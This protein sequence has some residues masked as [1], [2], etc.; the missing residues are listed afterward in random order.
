MAPAGRTGSCA[1]SARCARRTTCRRVRGR[2]TRRTMVDPVA[3]AFR[4]LGHFWLEEVRPDDIATIAALPELG[5]ALPE[6]GAAA[7]DDLA[8]EYQRLFGFNLPPY[9]SVFI[10][11]SAML[12]APVTA[13]VQALY[14]RGNWSPP[15]D[16]RVGAPDHLGLELLALADGLADGRHEFARR[17]HAEHLALWVP[18]LIQ[19]LRRLAP[20]P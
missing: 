18:P 12:F 4:I 17:L 2:N 14:R 19:A 7:L 13:R 15:A 3:D 6:T 20:Q 5:D 10:D 1:P 11:P 8:V 9:E 16:V